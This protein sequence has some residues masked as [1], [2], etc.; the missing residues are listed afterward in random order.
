[1]GGNAPA[2]VFENASRE[3]LASRC[4]NVMSDLAR[5]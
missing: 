2:W 4:S 3:A 5:A 1:M